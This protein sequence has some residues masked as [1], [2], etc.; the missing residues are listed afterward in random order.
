MLR[1]L[2]KALHALGKASGFMCMPIKCQR[3][4]EHLGCHLSLSHFVLWPLQ[5]SSRVA[6]ESETTEQGPPRAHSSTASHA[7]PTQQG[8]ARSPHGST[9]APAFSEHASAA[10][11]PQFAF[12]VPGHGS[13]RAPDDAV[14]QPQTP[15]MYLTGA[16]PSTFS[17]VASSHQDV[18]PGFA[19]S[20]S[21]SRLQYGSAEAFPR[22]VS[23]AQPLQLS[24]ARATSGGQRQS[25][26]QSST[27][28][29]TGNAGASLA[30][31]PH[32]HQQ[33]PSSGM[34]D[35][36]KAQN[37]ILTV[38]QAALSSTNVGD[39][40][41]AARLIL[42]LLSGHPDLQSLSEA[43][44]NH[45]LHVTFIRFT[46][47]DVSVHSVELG[48]RTVS[49]RVLHILASQPTLHTRLLAS[50]ICESLSDALHRL[51]SNFPLNGIAAVVVAALGHL[52][53]AGTP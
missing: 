50:G 14:A 6:S 53:L 37:D 22:S 34:N 18:G 29:P 20:A 9:P 47:R 24:I 33:C 26:Q 38:Q 43:I 17:R 40:M 4:T 16:V 21:R 41:A 30:A 5:A 36:L 44:V 2:S 23:H 12:R 27:R 42:D 10:A 28:I 7:Q 48:L 45:Q 39:R 3:A 46:A 19:E 1:L 35:I 31:S 15:H 13:A 51:L 52:C 25:A 32:G 11:S 49:L 8:S